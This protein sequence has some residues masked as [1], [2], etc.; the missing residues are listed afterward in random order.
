[1][2]SRFAILQVVILMAMFNSVFAETSRESEVKTINAR[3]WGQ[4]IEGQALSIATKKSEYAPAERVVLNIALRNEGSVDVLAPKRSPLAIYEVRVLGPD[5]KEV[6]HTL[7]GEKFSTSGKRGSMSVVCLKP[8]QQIF[9][10]IDLSRLVDISVP[11]KY[12]LS[13]SRFVLKSGTKQGAK[14]ESN[15]LEIVIDD[16]LGGEFQENMPRT[17]SN[18]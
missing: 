12:G 2:M 9:A 5:G 4:A 18:P 8:G 14:A 13:V 6:P 16:A 17:K 10:E 7:W 15:E 3:R 1:M 11:G